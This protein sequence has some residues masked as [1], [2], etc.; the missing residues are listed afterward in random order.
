MLKHILSFEAKGLLN[1]RNIIIFCAI[2]VL[3]TVF[4]WEGITDYKLIIANKKPFQETERDKVSSHIH[5]TFYGIR[6]VRLLFIPSPISIMFND[7][8]VFKGMTAHID[9]AE[10][11]NISNSFK[12]KDLFSDSGGYMD[13]AGIIFMI[14]LFVALIYG[15][16]ATR[17]TEYLKLVSILYGH[18]NP[19]LLIILARAILL[20]VVF[21]LL[22]A[23]PAAWATLNGMN[24]PGVFYLVFVMG[25][26]LVITFFILTGALIGEWKNKSVQFIALPV[27]YFVLV[28]CIPWLVQ[29]AV[30]MEAKEGIQ[31]IYNFEYQTFKY[32]MDFEKQFYERF[33]VWKSGQVAP[34]KIKTMIEN[35]KASVYKILRKKEVERLS[36]ILK[37][38]DNYQTIAAVFPT[39]FYLSINRELSSKGF[40][41]VINFY[42]YAYDMKFKFIEFYLERKFYRSLPES[43]VESFIKNNE[44][45]FEAK[46]HLPGNFRF[47]LLISTFWLFVLTVIIWFLSNRHF[48]LKPVGK[49]ETKFDPEDCK[50]N[51]TTV[52]LTPNPEHK[53]KLLAIYRFQKTDFLS[54]PSPGCLPDNAAVKDLFSFFRRDVTGNLEEVAH[55]SGYLLTPEYRALVILELVKSQK[56]DIL[57]FDNFLSGL[58]ESFITYFA[59]SL[60]ELKKEKRV[61]YFSKSLVK[62]GN[63]YL[64][65]ADEEIKF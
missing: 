17:N 58:S 51:K 65:F 9:T 50:L 21:L 15:Y 23:L 57:I 33:G 11:L 48:S 18:R 24:T 45:L 53:A 37:R 38:V 26:A 12:G 60:E 31:S 41:N 8:S 20:N 27:V 61:I 22:C 35:S 44:D 28:F 34:E 6:G 54:V 30:Y 13:F 42:R 49:E 3:L 4:C 2:F 14:S 7:L 5:Y 56:S 64:Q 47:G 52:I 25:L 43:G 39:S 16:D 36:G 10:K 19:T 29:K 40:Q 46:S 55:Q 1:K 59:E 32:V 63:Q 62:F